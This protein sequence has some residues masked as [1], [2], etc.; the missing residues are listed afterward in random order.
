MWVL[1]KSTHQVPDGEVLEASV[2]VRAAH[3]AELLRVLD[4][5][6]GVEGDPVRQGEGQV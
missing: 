3:S 4:V 1:K 6:V 2:G 5:V